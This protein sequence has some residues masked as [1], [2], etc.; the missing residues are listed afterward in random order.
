MISTATSSAEAKAKAKGVKAGSNY[1]VQIGSK[2]HEAN[3]DICCTHFTKL[4]AER[5]CMWVG[6][7][8]LGA[9]AMAT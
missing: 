8:V 1:S 2:S 9:L 4:T 6:R 3:T 5:L 7:L